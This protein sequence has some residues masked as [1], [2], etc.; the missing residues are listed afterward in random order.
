[1]FSRKNCDIRREFWAK[2]PLVPKTQVGIT[3]KKN[4]NETL[5][6]RIPPGACS[7]H[8]IVGDRYVLAVGSSGAARLRLLDEVYGSA[9]RQM[10]TAAGLRPGMRVADIGCGIGSVTHWLAEH[11]GGTGEVL[12]ID[13]SGEQ[14]QLARAA[15]RSANAAKVTFREGSAYQTGLP[16]ESFDLV[17]CRFL[18]CHLLRP[19][20]ALR[21]MQAL[22]RPGG[23]LVCQDLNFA[24]LFSEPT[25]CAYRRSV[26]LSLALADIRGVDYCFGS[27]LE[28]SIRAAGFAETETRVDQ[29]WSLCVEAK[30]LW[31]YTFLESAPAMVEAGLVQQREIDQ[32]AA[33]L[34]SAAADRNTHLAVWKMH[35]VSA[36]KKL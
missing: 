33:E 14:L 30:R 24:S 7:R 8:P 36:R 19:V 21:E 34:A 2:H 32:L 22:L 31:E 27:K 26:E 1:M 3:K 4:R 35:G 15:A 5:T 11:A 23:I 13:A 16:R 20:H 9:S 25:N 28:D 17:Y 29:P 18:L 6:S 10:L 12:G